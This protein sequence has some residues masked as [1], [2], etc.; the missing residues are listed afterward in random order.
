MNS[1]PLF[2]FERNRYYAGKMLTS[3][4]F[5]AEQGYVNDKRRFLNNLMF[6][7]GIVCGCNVYSLDD[8]SI[9]VE[10]GLAIDRLGREIVVDTSVVK[11]LSAITGFE[12]V[13]SNLVTLCLKYKEEQVHPVY[14][15]NKQG[16]SSEYEFNRI[17]EGYELFLMDTEE[18]RN[19]FEMESEFLTRGVIYQDGDYEI[20][21]IL[22]A[23]VCR[24]RYVKVQLKATKT[25][26]ADAALS[27]EGSLQTP[28][29]LTSEDTHELKISLANMRLME[30]ESISQEY[31]VFVQDTQANETS[32]ILKKDSVKVRGEQL[33]M[34]SDF[35]M[36]VLIS[37]VNP[38]DLVNR[39]LG[40]VSLE[41]Q[42]MGNTQ[43]F[44]CLADIA[45]LR[46]EG[47]YIIEN[48]EEKDVKRY[49]EAPAQ[50]TIRSEYL[51][52]F[53]GTERLGVGLKEET[54]AIISSARNSY[55]E[56]SMQI[57][58]GTVEIP[59][60]GKAKAGEVFFSGEVMH[61]L[62]AGSVYVEIGQEFIDEDRVKGAST[63]STVF[64][65]GNLFAESTKRIPKTEKAVKV[66]NDKGSFVAAISFAEDTEC[67]MLTY[68]WVAV[69]FANND[70][71]DIENESEKQWIEAETPTVVLGTRESYYFGVKFHDMDKCS[72]GYE[73]SEEDGGQI[74]V[75][76]VYTAP[77]K[78]GV[79]EIKIYCMDRPYICTYAYAIVK[80]K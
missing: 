80:K 13:E 58:T 54:E 24:N 35:T 36:K 25:S 5:A 76:G 74:T 43:D 12:S 47:A 40:K 28:S 21:L 63:K 23:T 62:G 3:A 1:N 2:P 7:S 53:R 55:G 77:N 19:C 56:G 57:A 51:D 72:I 61:G 78:D 33:D 52:F 49:I 60:G 64:G 20:Q 68:R 26:S 44:I 73:V 66:L 75:D 59:V 14:A 39:E 6:G 29:F 30:G 67:L 50:N 18:T 38:R 32:L 45:L 37:D 31:W 70:T 4:D 42:N 41:L 34:D 27:F 46:T 69:K 17:Q 9:F 22:P 8:L 16:A 71:L 10:S 79:F 48:I 11:K 65:N 15:V